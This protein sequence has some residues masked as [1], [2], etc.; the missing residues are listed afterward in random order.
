MKCF[1]YIYHT[2]FKYPLHRPRENRANLESELVSNSHILPAS[3]FGIL[4]GYK[5]APERSAHQTAEKSEEMGCI[6]KKVAY[7]ARRR[8][9]S[10]SGSREVVLRYTEPPVG[11]VSEENTNELS[12]PNNSA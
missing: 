4:D 5:S 11:S 8:Q 10:L 2:F 12:C 9:K 6:T 7:S 1:T 3:R